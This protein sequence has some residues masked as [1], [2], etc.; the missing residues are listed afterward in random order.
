MLL[1]TYHILCLDIQANVNRNTFMWCFPLVFFPPQLCSF[2][3][4]VLLRIIME[5]FC[6][7]RQADTHSPT[8]PLTFS[9][10]NVEYGALGLAMMCFN[11]NVLI[12]SLLRIGDAL[13][14]SRLI[15]EGLRIFRSCFASTVEHL[16]Y[17]WVTR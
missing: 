2:S 4:S 1:I 14:T 5:T 17:R 15:L 10:C 11:L 6:W 8:H 12:S 7:K 13:F 16:D 9:W 3:A